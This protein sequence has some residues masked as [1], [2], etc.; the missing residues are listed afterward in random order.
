MTDGI[1][2]FEE[3]FDGYFKGDH[4]YWS[5]VTGFKY[6]SNADHI[7]VLQLFNP[8]IKVLSTSKGAPWS[9]RAAQINGTNYGKR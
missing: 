9:S 7:K 8:S 5:S 2:K 6:L 4:V 3:N 1:F